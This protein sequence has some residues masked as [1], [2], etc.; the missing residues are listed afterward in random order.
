MNEIFNK[1]RVRFLRYWK[2]IFLQISL[3]IITIYI[4]LLFLSIEH[5]VII[6]SIAATA[7]IVFTMPKS[8]AARPKNVIGGHLI[9]LLTGLFST[10]LYSYYINN[11]LVYAFAVGLSI[12]LMIL[13]DTEHPPASGTALGVSIKGFTSDVIIAV[14]T[15]S[16]ILSLFH[17]L[18][19]KFLIDLA[20]TK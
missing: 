4:V 6:S 9:G 2:N 20:R 5:A 1:S 12:F 18:F 3:A 16:I 8:I 13:T 19:K 17:Q 14:V 15:S 7:F 11:I 10:F